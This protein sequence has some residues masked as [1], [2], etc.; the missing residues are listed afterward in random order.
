VKPPARK[1]LFVDDRWIAHTHAVH[2]SVGKPWKYP[3]NPLIVA[4]RPWEGGLKLY[5]TVL[6]DNGRLRM[7][8]QMVNFAERDLRFAT[9][10]GY[11]ESRDG[12]KWTKPAKGIVHPVHGRTNLLMTSHGRSHLC[13]PSVV[14]DDTDP[15]PQRRY[16]LIFFDAM[17]ADDLA[18]LGSP[19]PVSRTVPGWRG[20]E[21]EGMF[22]CTSRDGLRWSRPA[23][24]AFAGP[25]DVASVS[26]L[27]DGRLY[28]AYKTS[29]RHDRHFRVIE[30]AESWDGLHWQS[31]GPVLEPDWH[32]PH[33]TEFY[34]MSP[35]EYHD[36]LLGLICVYQNSPDDKS[37]DIQ[38]ATSHDGATWNR[39][40]DRAVFLPRGGRGEWDAGGL[41]VAS[42]PVLPEPG[43]TDPILL[44]YSAI[45]ARHDDMRY[46]EWSVGV[47]A[48]R[49]D[50]WASLDTGYFVGEVLTH[51]VLATTNRL[52]INADCRHGWL[53]VHLMDAESAQVLASSQTLKETDV[54]SR[55]LI[56]KQKKAFAG[57]LVRLVVEMRRASFYSFWFESSGDRTTAS[58]T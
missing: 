2:R 3:G 12:L 13:S 18:T 54:V 28:A 55:Q 4:D 49:Q 57:K 19:F 51:P 44:Y 46:K 35:F 26:Q 29:L 21:G 48:L 6:R 47:A 39:A 34:G 22:V 36:N 15:D 56:W 1:Y 16:K 52:Y 32:D 45:S 41:Y 14:R 53:R 33:G 25:N 58:A 30:G 7:W 38:L 5:G 40:A 43:T 9:G 24:P 50:G 17:S 20:V 23:Q 11:A 31:H 10:V 8:Y 42:T 27:S 37:L